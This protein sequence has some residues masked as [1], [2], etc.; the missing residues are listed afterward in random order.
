MNERDLVWY[1]YVNGLTYHRYG[2]VAKHL[3]EGVELEL[4]RQ[5]DNPHDNK[6]VAVFFQDKQVAWIP[7]LYNQNIARWL[8]EGHELKV[9]VAE[10]N[11][12]SDYNRRLKVQVFRYNTT[13]NQKDTDIMANI[14]TGASVGN[15]ATSSSVLGNIGRTNLSAAKSA[16]FLEAGRIANKEVTKLVGK[17]LP[18]MVRGYADTPFGR[19]LTAN[20]AV[21]AAAHFRPEDDKLQQLAEAM[22]VQA[23]QELLQTLEI[24]E[25]LES[26]LESPKIKAAL[27]KLKKA[28]AEQE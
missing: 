28:E 14:N 4:R 17:V 3:S 21:M 27:G 6:A 12:G 11:R 18:I 7:A 22:Q 13:T 16:A 1:G 5:K 15:T 2:E 26:L 10:H 20:V 25:F 9:F 19:L 24:D 23:Y 8:D